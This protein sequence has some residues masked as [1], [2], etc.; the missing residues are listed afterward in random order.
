[1][2][3]HDIVSF[4][5]SNVYMIGHWISYFYHIKSIA[6][7]V[8]MSPIL[9]SFFVLF[10]LFRLPISH[11]SSFLLLVTHLHIL[12][13]SYFVT[14]HQPVH[15]PSYQS[16]NMLTI[17]DTQSHPDTHIHILSLF[18]SHAHTL[19]LSLPHTRT[20]KLTLTLSYTHQPITVCP[21]LRSCQSKCTL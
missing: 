19:S 8:E 1:M 20:H 4:L 21:Y 17:T 12:L 9:S 6:D 2:S 15:Q 5:H 10:H 18:L 7:R 11:L 14:L 16:S 13:F 3:K